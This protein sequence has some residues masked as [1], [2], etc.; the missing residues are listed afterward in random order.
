MTGVRTGEAGE[1]QANRR[2]EV[3]IAV[4]L[5]LFTAPII[6]VW[7]AQPAS[8]YLFAVAVWDDH[9]L[10]LDRYEYALGIDRAVVDGHIVSDKAPYQPL[11]SVPFYA[12]YRLVGGQP[13]PTEIPEDPAFGLWW[14]SLWSSTVPAIALA[15][16]MRRLVQRVHPAYATRV[17]LALAIGTVL[18]PFSSLLFGHMLAALGVFG[19]WYLLRDGD[20]TNGAL[21]GA[22]A[23]MAAAVGTEFTM[24]VAVAAVM[25][26]SIAVYRWRLIATCIGGLLGALPLLAYNA[27]VF[28]SPFRV[29]YQG[30]LPNF[31]GEGALG[32]YNLR[33]PV[34][35]EVARALI[36]DR[37]LL[38]L[39]PVMVLAIIG[40]VLAIRKHRSTSRDAWLALVLLVIF[41][42]LTT[43]IDGIGG[44]TPGPRYLIPI[45]PF[46]AL[47]L[48][49]AWQRFPKA[50]SITAR[51]GG[52]F[53]VLA[54][55]TDPV[56]PGNAVNAPRLWIEMAARG[57]F[58]KSWPGLVL[59]SWSVLLFVAAGVAV[60]VKVLA[61]DEG[62]RRPSRRA[63][64]PAPTADG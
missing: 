31:Q 16:L 23:L 21:V 33:V 63:A 29:A 38:F 60:L 45:I 6:Q 53:M 27:L 56:L 58:G 50:C 7:S 1:R 24:I 35:L 47:P 62:L 9:S 55:V 13:V 18:L 46:F 2:I 4:A 26:A 52:F 25:V 12:L 43:G 19:G 64:R 14:V 20:R 54:S 42:V 34:P 11:L 10:E 51:I 8:R 59:P 32:V 39:T 30:Y 17:A 28:G 48:A 36:G 57:A 41:V 15:L 49:E 40:A 22:G 37:G 61:L 5:L 3:L 44:D